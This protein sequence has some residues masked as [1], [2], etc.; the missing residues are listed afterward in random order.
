M[1]RKHL[2][3][4]LPLLLL[5]AAA[6]APRRSATD[7]VPAPTATGDRVTITLEPMP[8]KYQDRTGSLLDLFAASADSVFWCG[9]NRP[10]PHSWLSP[11]VICR[12][13]TDFGVDFCAESGELVEALEFASVG[14][15]FYRVSL[16]FGDDD[17][18]RP[19]VYL[20]RFRHRDST[21][22]ESKIELH[23]PR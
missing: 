10:N 23:P 3:L 20:L 9:P 17:R 21:V 15:G 8:R 16:S 14:P 18:P 12:E 11:S 13:R 4:M 6:G 7:S 1:S 5:L 2:F 19:G 22:F